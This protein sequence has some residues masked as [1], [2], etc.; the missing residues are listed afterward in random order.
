MTMASSPVS[1]DAAEPRGSAAP[2]LAE[3]Q[4]QAQARGEIVRERMTR[5]HRAVVGREPDRFGLGNEIPDRQHETVIADD[6]AVAE[7]LGA[8][9][10]RSERVVRHLGAKHDD[11]RIADARS[12][13][14]PSGLGCRL[15]G[16]AQ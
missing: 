3:R 8:E 12:K 2:E 9:N 10:R 11:Q 15:A 1:I 14:R 16:N 5:N 4:D 6:D 13:R 7:S